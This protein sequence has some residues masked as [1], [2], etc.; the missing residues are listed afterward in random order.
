MNVENI[1]S[2]ETVIFNENTN[3]LNIVD[4]T[5]LPNKIE[6]LS[7][8]N[9]K[10]VWDAIKLLSVRGAPAIGVAAA[11]GAYLGA[12]RI[13][14]NDYPTF[15]TEYEKISSYLASS[16]PTAVNLC[17]ALDRL[18]E[19][20]KANCKLSPREITSLLLKESH[21][22]REE[23]IVMSKNIG[24]YGLSLLQPNMGILTHCNAG[25]L[26]T[27]RYGTATA[28]MYLG[29][30][31]GYNFKIFADETRPLLQGARLTSFELSNAGMDV[32]L[33]C[34]NMAASLMKEGKIQAVF[35][36]CDRVAANGD[37]ANK[38]G[39]LG[40]AIMAKYFNIPFYICAP[41][42]TVDFACLTGSDIV[43]EQRD[44]FEISNMWYSEPMA[45]EGV[46]CY[47]PAF[48]VTDKDLITAIVTDKGI[49]YPPFSESLKL[50]LKG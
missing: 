49:A 16:R 43:I 28:P 5:K 42:S 12:T 14:A 36:G 39:T 45:P 4:Q 33:I 8:E 32:T 47:N 13:S 37:S 50:L 6:I 19:I 38:I 10:E 18:M 26:A 25:Q 44:M 17:W 35:T 23:D 9:E 30:Q 46:K 11:Y 1:L 20:V 21:L 31:Q 48:D 29:F 15:L 22:I 2:F 3:S 7:L 40:V 41:S 24:E 34:D 27:I